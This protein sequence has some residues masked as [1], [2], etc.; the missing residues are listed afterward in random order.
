[1]IS[2]HLPLQLRRCISLLPAAIL[3]LSL[4][5]SAGARAQSGV[6]TAP[7]AFMTAHQTPLAGAGG[8]GSVE[9]YGVAGFPGIGLGVGFGIN[10]RFGIRGQFTTLGSP[11]RSFTESGIDYNGKLR[12]DMIGVYLDGFVSGGFRITGGLS[13]ND[14]N[15]R[16]SGVPAGSGSVTINGA[17]VAY[18][19]GDS[20]SFE[21][22]T[23]N[24]APYLGIGFGHAPNTKGWSFSFDAGIHFA[25][26][27]ARFD[28]SQSVR[29]RLTA[30]GRNAQA[31]IDAEQAKVQKEFD[32][33]PFWPAV[34]LGIS[35]R[36]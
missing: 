34:M 32:R 26:F 14:L 4:A 1:M 2:V 23:P 7:P 35:Y 19:A 3:G 22:T 15:V 13:I 30:S 11:E 9:L 29:D 6:V 24:V 16:G 17:T 31:D 18:G 20:I 33:L 25:K 8:A 28:T 21:A 36:F 12:S 10:E 27:T 5:W